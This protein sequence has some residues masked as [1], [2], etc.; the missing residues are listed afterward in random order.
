MSRVYALFTTVVLIGGCAGAVA[1]PRS[2][3]RTAE[4]GVS[5]T[6]RIGR[7]GG[8][9][10][11]VCRSDTGGTCIIGASTSGSPRVAAVSVYLH[12]GRVPAT[13]SGAVLIGFVDGP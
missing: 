3:S 11:D 6:I 2:P 1:P 10:H 9:A 7:P 4:P 5:W 13:F 12:P 8:D